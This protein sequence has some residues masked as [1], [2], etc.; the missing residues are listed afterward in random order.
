MTAGVILQSLT[1]KGA[2]E[3]KKLLVMNHRSYRKKKN[4]HVVHC[5]QHPIRYH[6][7]GV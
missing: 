1:V 4:L 3:I 5:Q 2:L 6:A 7:N